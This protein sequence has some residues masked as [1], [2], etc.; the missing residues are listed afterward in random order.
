M[1]KTSAIVAIL[2]ISLVAVTSVS[3]ALLYTLSIPSTITIQSDGL[4]LYA[5]DCTTPI[6]SMTFGPV[7]AGSTTFLVTC[8]KPSGSS[9]IWLTSNSLTSTLPST[10]GALNWKIVQKQG[11]YVLTPPIQ[12]VPGDPGSTMYLNFTIGTLSSAPSGSTSFTVTLSG[13]SSS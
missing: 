9:A 11:G 10:V 6:S 3:A 4:N 5:S 7:S 8:L 12:L 2:A 1:K 13:F